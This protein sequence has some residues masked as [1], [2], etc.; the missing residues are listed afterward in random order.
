MVDQPRV[1]HGE[2]HFGNG[3]RP[4]A[5]LCNLFFLAVVQGMSAEVSDG[6]HQALTAN[7]IRGLNGE[8][9]A[10]NDNVIRSEFAEA[11]DA[12]AA[13]TSEETT[14][15]FHW[16]AKSAVLSVVLFVVAGVCEIGGG[17]MVWKAIREGKQ[18]WWAIIGS[19][20]L[21]AYGFIPTLQPTSS[22]GRVYAVYGGFFIILSFL[23]GWAFD[24]D[25]PDTGDAVGGAI[26]LVGVLLILF[27]PR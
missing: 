9:H 21:I 14:S 1:S 2:P 27:W 4:L 17:W 20:I 19:A 15:S 26:S 13:S 6:Q 12:E 25:R 24:G 11:A 18:F 5:H 22:F 8:P 7:G 3:M 16:T 23:W 10:S